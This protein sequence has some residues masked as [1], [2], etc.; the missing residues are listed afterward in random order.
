MDATSS[1]SERLKCSLAVETLRRWGVLKLRAMGV[2]MLPSLWPGDLL[3][4]QS[5][6]AER[7]E[8]GEI[9][10]YLGH[11][12]F[13]IHRVIS[14]NVCRGKLV[15]IVRGDCM[16]ENDP[17]VLSDAVLG[18]ITQIHRNGLTLL[19]VRKLSLSERA[20]AHMLCRSD[21][22]RRSALRF[23]CRQRRDGGRRQVKL[24]EAAS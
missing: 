19:P 1:A 9:V 24:V 11:D 3:T 17:A 8:P 22:F 14:K 10:L 23:V 2:S 13:F 4:I 16:P 12:R 21:L 18:K 7:I 20:I 6:I 5:E 15:L